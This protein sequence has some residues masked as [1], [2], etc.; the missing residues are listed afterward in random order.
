MREQYEPNANEQIKRVS[1]RSGGAGYA[2]SGV[3][4]RETRSA[5]GVLT[6]G[7]LLAER[8]KSPK[9]SNGKVVRLGR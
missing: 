9:L 7:A 8:A 2:H 4:P 3:V 5:E 6:D 1:V